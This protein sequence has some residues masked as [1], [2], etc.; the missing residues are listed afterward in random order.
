VGQEEE[1]QRVDGAVEPTEENGSDTDT[2]LR[3]KV[4]I[5]GGTAIEITERITTARSYVAKGRQDGSGLVTL[6]TAPRNRIVIN[7]DRL[8][9]MEELVR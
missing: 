7:I 5:A 2:T 9:Y 1:A 4:Y 6:R 3:T 8:L